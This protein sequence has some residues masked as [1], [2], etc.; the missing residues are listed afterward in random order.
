MLRNTTRFSE[1]EII[2]DLPQVVLQAVT[3]LRL[4]VIRCFFEFLGEM[5]SLKIR[6][7][8]CTVNFNWAIPGLP[9]YVTRACHSSVAPSHETCHATCYVMLAY[10]S[11]KMHLS[12]LRA[13]L[14][15]VYFFQVFFLS[16]TSYRG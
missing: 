12:I 13:S 11:L 6:G 16:S 1:T 5:T 14:I 2:T 7:I 4:C 9:Q 15:C 3:L 10:S 8:H